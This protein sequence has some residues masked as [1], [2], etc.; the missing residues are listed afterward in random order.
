MISIQKNGNKMTLLVQKERK[1]RY[2]TIPFKATKFGLINKTKLNLTKKSYALP[3][4][5]SACCASLSK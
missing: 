3:F 5:E 4:T 2:L 1:E